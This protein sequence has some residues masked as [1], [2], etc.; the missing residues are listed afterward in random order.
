MDPIPI[1]KIKM[2]KHKWL[3]TKIKYDDELLYNDIICDISHI[4]HQWILDKD[5]L[6]LHEEYPVLQQHII[7]LY[8]PFVEK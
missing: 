1:T 6:I 8:L 4:I 2:N 5:D 3:T 7:N